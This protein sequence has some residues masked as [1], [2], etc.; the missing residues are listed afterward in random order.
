MSIRRLHFCLD[1]LKGAIITYAI[2]AILLISAFCFAS[3]GLINDK[4]L[5]IIEKA[6]GNNVDLMIYV[7][8]ALGG[9]VGFIFNIGFR[10]INKKIPTSMQGLFGIVYWKVAALCGG[11]GVILENHT[12]MKYVRD[13]LAKKYPGLTITLAGDGIVGQAL[14]ASPVVEAANEALNQLDKAGA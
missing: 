5:P 11:S 9:I 6:L 10:V 3:D 12:D 8:G 1:V 13:E 2:F 7:L 14:K 4:L